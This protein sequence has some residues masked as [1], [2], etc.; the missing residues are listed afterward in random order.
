MMEILTLNKIASCGLDL[1]DKNVF[2][3]S[4]DAKDPD[5]IIL[6]S[7]NMHEMELGDNLKAVARAGAGTNNIPIEKCSEKGIVVFNTPGA[8]ANAVKELVLAGLFLSSRKISQS[9]EWAKTLKGEGENV[10]KLVEKGK[11]NFVGPE[12]EGKKL[13][14]IGLG[15]IGVMVANTA[16]HLGMEVIGYDPYISVDA[17]WGLSRH[18][19]KANELKDL[20]AECDYITLHVPLNDATKNMINDEL[21][22]VMKKGARILN[23]ARGGLVDDAALEKAIANGTV[24]TYVTDFPNE[25]ILC[26]DNVVA[27]PHLGASTPESEDNCAKMASVEI[28]DYLCEGNIVNS[29]NFPNCSLAREGKT[30]ITIAHKNVPNCV[31]NFTNLCAKD[32]CNIVNMINKSKKDMA[33]TIIDL[34]DD[35]PES[36]KADFEALENVLKVRVIK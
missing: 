34:D 29:V 15:A 18:V 22:A 31:S 36:V 28:Q 35:I 7:F 4:D 27:I 25:K 16:Y 20:V 13:G 32:N 5:G 23:F 24:A 30:R 10:G 26:M 8:N 1:L 33:Y 12:I 6:R 17:A 3:I 11:S 9:I 2:N 14:I 19:R 21:F